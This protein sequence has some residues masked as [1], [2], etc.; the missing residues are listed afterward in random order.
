MGIPWDVPVIMVEKPNTMKNTMTCA[1]FCFGSVCFHQSVKRFTFCTLTFGNNVY[2]HK[3]T[4]ID[5]LKTRIKN[6]ITAMTANTVHKFLYFL[7]LG[8]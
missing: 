5:Y 3:Q 8:W 7:Y 4:C 6:S 2:P 1:I